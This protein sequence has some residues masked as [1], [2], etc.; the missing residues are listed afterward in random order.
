MAGKPKH[1]EHEDQ[2]APQP[3]PEAEPEQ[4]PALEG[5][6]GIPSYQD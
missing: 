5:N 6:P 3:K 4:E 2:P 1:V